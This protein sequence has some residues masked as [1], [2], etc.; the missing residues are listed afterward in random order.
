L[1][2]R[3]VKSFDLAAALSNCSCI[4]S[5]NRYLLIVIRE[6]RRMSIAN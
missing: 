3:L 1:V 5:V 2:G 6:C 4:W